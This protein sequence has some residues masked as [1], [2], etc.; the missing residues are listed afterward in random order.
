MAAL[1]DT[2]LP[3]VLFLAF[4]AVDAVDAVQPPGLAIIDGKI[5]TIENDEICRYIFMTPR[6]R[7]QKLIKEEGAT[8]PIRPNTCPVRDDY[9]E[10][11][12]GGD[13]LMVDEHGYQRWTNPAELSP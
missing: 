13:L 2:T 12:S 8:C 4:V 11:G 3:V 10:C 6:A 1:K 5:G 9:G 7:W